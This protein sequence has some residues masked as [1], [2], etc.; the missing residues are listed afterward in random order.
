MFESR[1]S[2]NICT[3]SPGISAPFVLMYA[4]SVYVPAGRLL[5]VCTA[6]TRPVFEAVFDTLTEFLVRLYL[7][8]STVTEAPAESL[9]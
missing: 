8:L 2:A 6:F 7:L 1:I 9:V 4:D 5:T 3:P